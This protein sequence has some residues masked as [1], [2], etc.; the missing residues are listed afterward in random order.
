M[1]DYFDATPGNKFCCSGRLPLVRG[2][3]HLDGLTLQ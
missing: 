2:V 1:D 3:L